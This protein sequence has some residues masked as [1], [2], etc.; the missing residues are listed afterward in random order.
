MSPSELRER[1]GHPLGT[2]FFDRPTARVARDL[3]GRW[4]VVRDRRGLR[5][6]RIVE[7]EAYVARDPA[8]HA[9]RG[10]TE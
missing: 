9:D 10:R 3:L 5:A 1:F 6:A 2:E 8:N 4:I 7:T